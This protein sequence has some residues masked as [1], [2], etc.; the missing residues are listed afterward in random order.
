MIHCEWESWCSS[1]LSSEFINTPVRK[2]WIAA[3]SG[4]PFLGVTR[5]ALVW[6]KHKYVSHSIHLCGCMMKATELH[7]KDDEPLQIQ[8]SQR[9]EKGGWEMEARGPNPSFVTS[10]SFL[11]SPRGDK[12]RT[13]DIAAQKSILSEVVL[14]SYKNCVCVRLRSY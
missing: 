3:I 12:K 5:F 8:N 14:D 11:Y 6:R 9:A 7:Q 13:S 2:S 1:L 4:S 10:S